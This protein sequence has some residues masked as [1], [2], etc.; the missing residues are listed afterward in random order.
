MLLGSYSGGTFYHLKAALYSHALWDS[1]RQGVARFLKEWSPKEKVLVLIGPSAGYSLPTDFLS[2]FESI[3]AYEP[4][5]VARL[6]FERRTG[7]KPR[8]K[9]HYLLEENL[10]GGAVLISNLL[11]QLEIDVAEF[12]PR[13]LRQLS[14]R[15]FASYHDIFSGTKV[16]FH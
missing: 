3:I 1:H 4:D 10:P 16:D 6:I 2:Q 8:W 7:L 9:G 12:K 5:P 13:L 14:G 15:E 11:G